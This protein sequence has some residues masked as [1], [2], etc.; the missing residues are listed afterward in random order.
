[1]H[2]SDYMSN[3]LGSEKVYVNGEL[4]FRWKPKAGDLEKF[5]YK[6]TRSQRPDGAPN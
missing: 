6:Q 1:M 2:S 4:D 5:K 3:N